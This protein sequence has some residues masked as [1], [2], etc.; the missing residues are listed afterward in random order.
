MRVDL[1]LDRWFLTLI[2]GFR[3]VFKLSNENTIL[4]DACFM[5]NYL[6]LDEGQDVISTPNMFYFY[7]IFRRQNLQMLI[8]V[9]PFE[10]F[11]FF[12]LISQEW[13]I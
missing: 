1:E 2:S 12:S 10:I 13:S 8:N 6:V 11:V 7:E 4:T 3:G 5:I 9:F